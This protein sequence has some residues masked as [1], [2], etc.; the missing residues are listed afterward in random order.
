[1]CAGALIT[2]LYLFIL[3]GKPTDS[4]CRARLWLTNL[5]LVIMFLGLI[6]RSYRIYLICVKKGIR[7]RKLTDLHLMKYVAAVVLMYSVLLIV[8]TIV[9]DVRVRKT[10]NNS[11][12]LE[13]TLVCKS[14]D[15]NLW[16]GILFSL[17]GCV[18]AIGVYLGIGKPWM[19]TKV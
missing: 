12:P 6:T 13:Y 15:E 18:L 5:G 4:I 11:H 17:E 9:G 7:L 3:V 16:N 1:M 8:I 14:E 2:C 19:Y 10:Q